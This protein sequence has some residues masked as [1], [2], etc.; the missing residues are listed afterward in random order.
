MRRRTFLTS[1]LALP[2][3]SLVAACGAASTQRTSG[4]PFRL[5]I[6]G[7]TNFAESYD[8]EEDGQVTTPVAEYGY[9]HSL[10]RLAP[11]LK[12]ADYTV[13]NLETALTR[14]QAGLPRKAYRHWSDA[15]KTTEQLR[16]HG[17]DAVGLANNHTLDFGLAGLE[18]T[19][20]ALRHDGIKWFGA[21]DNVYDA[22]LPLIVRAPT[23]DGR[24]RHVAF[25]GMFEYRRQYDT[26]Y[27]FYASARTGGTK[28]L[29]VAEFARMVRRY[30][31]RHPSLFVIAYSHWGRNYA[32][33]TD[34]Q[35]AKA[36]ALI[37]AG[38]DMVIG[39]HAHVLQEIEQYRGK[40][41]LYGIGNFMFNAPGRFA[42]HPDV[43][44]YGLAVELLFPGSR[45][46]PPEP[47][48]YPIL[49]NNALTGFQPRLANSEEFQT[50]FDT[51]AQR[52]DDATRA[53]LASGGD[54]MGR[55][56]RLG[57]G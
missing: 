55:F 15:S 51:L 42:G 49:S 5:L 57:V 31:R 7:D 20:E 27:Q 6:G 12:R 17:V 28:R 39:H 43:L 14:P 24:G 37:D 4:G 18:D 45:T 1:S 38:A 34:Y 16:Q 10:V 50:V 53:H 26:A 29:D 32:W 47:R 23:E 40:W 35:N 36:K 8:I 46:A 52:S 25:F 41:I 22:S 21:G 30:R 19:F 54:D 13:L 56:I 48:L 9:D 44:P 3:G 33:R 2:F 11:L